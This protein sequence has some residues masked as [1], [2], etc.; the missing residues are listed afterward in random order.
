MVSRSIDMTGQVFSALTVIRKST[1]TP[2]G[3]RWE[4]LCLCGNSTIAQRQHLLSGM[5]KSCG[6]GAFS[7]VIKHR[8]SNSVEHRTWRGMIARCYSE[9][10]PRYEYYG[11][12]GIYVCDKWRNSFVDFL[13]D[14]GRKPTPFHSIDRVDVNGPYS[15]ENCRWA[16]KKQQ[17]R[18]TRV[19]VTYTAHGLTMSLPEWADYLNV[20][21]ITLRKRLQAGHSFD[22]V[23]TD[24][25]I[26]YGSI[27]RS[28]L[29]RQL[30]PD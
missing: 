4:C 21:V 12:R 13:S 15:P 7:K 24:K 16:T 18:N 5:K 25:N 28:K 3:A 11:G 9:S 29:A 8:D 14:M 1:S 17:A 20:P 30:V 19:R 27:L 23:F 26:R 22:L 10:N 2:S 6:C